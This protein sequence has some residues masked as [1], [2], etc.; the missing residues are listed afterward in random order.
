MALYTKSISGATFLSVSS[1]SKVNLRLIR[2][3][4]LGSTNFVINFSFSS[5]LIILYKLGAK[6]QAS[7]ATCPASEQPFSPKT[8]S[9]LHCCSVKPYFINMGLTDSIIDSLALSK[10]IGS[11]WLVSGKDIL[12]GLLIFDLPQGLK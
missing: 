11:D 9:T 3:P 5:L 7:K 1:P 6:M 10:A 2:R 8:L 4:S 12:S